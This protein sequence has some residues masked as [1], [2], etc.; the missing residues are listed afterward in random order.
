MRSRALVLA[1]VLAGATTV[2]TGAA[3]PQGAPAAQ[4]QP[5]PAATSEGEG[6]MVHLFQ[7]PWESIADECQNVLGPNGYQAIQV[8]PPQE[9][10]VLGDEGH[11]WWQ[12]YQPVSYQLQTRRGDREQFA[13]MV[14]TCNDAGVKIYVDAVLNHMTGTESGTGSA[15]TEFRK[16]DYPGVY[17]DGDFSDCR[18]N[19]EN[20]D[21][22]WEV[23]H[24]ELVGLSDLKTDSEHVR[25]T[26][27]AFLNDLVDMGVSGFRVDAAKHM[28][29]EDIAAITSGLNNVPGTDAK[30]YVFQEVIADS[31]SDPHEYTGNGDVTEFSYSSVATAF[32]E[33]SLARL[34]ALPDEMS[35]GSEQ[36][37]VFVDNH[38]TQR[39]EPTLT[40]KDGKPY[41]L[42]NAFMLAY[43]YGTPKVMSSYEFDNSDA[44]PPAGEDGTTNQVDCDGQGWVCEHRNQAMTGMVGFHTAVY[45]TELANW[46]DNGNGQVSFQRGD[47]GFVAFNREGGELSKDFQSALP[48]GTYCNVM[49]GDLVDGQCT[50]ES[51]EVGEGGG[52][53]ATV[54]S[55][56]GL[57]L[58]VDAKVG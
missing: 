33:G 6:P 21:D 3:A 9:H 2:T 1:V 18:R 41:D 20:Y 57:A 15:G 14:S 22:T 29:P 48:A 34:A 53:Q 46:W 56:A 24:C 32:K 26:E 43:P 4:A 10:P 40:Y 58:H 50:G 47:K 54:P 37:V 19:I 38:D 28:P 35:L 27:I 13:N 30:P 39:S 25:T 17:G 51:V 5:S 11:P 42:A 8:S 45:G 52:F 36:A 55:N 23:R 49:T 16:Y 12:D 31:G 7:W 44:S